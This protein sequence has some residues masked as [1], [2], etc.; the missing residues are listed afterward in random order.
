[1]HQISLNYNHQ[2]EQLFANCSSEIVAMHFRLKHLVVQ[3]I[4]L[5]R[6]HVGVIDAVEVVIVVV[7]DVVEVVNKNTNAT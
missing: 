4:K 5:F 3:K 7:E 1:V 6:I 2:N